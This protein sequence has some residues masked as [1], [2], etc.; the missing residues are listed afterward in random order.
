MVWP[1][2]SPR[3]PIPLP[4]DLAERVAIVAP[5]PVL[6]S[7]F[8]SARRQPVRPIAHRDD[9]FDA[10]FDADTLFFDAFFGADGR[11]VLMGPPFLNLLPALQTMT[12]TAGPSRAPCQF[13]IRELDR[14]AQIHVRAPDGTTSLTLTATFGTVEIAISASEIDLFAGRR[15]LFTLS[16]NNHLRW[17]KDWIRFARDIHGAD[18]VLFYDNN[19]THYTKADLADA[20]GSLDGL[21][22]VRVIDWP[23]RY[24]PQGLDA[25]RFWDSDY[26]QHGAW[27]HARRR[28]LAAARS[29]QNADVDELVVPLTGSSV[30]EAAERDR[31]GITRYCGRWVT[32]ISDRPATERDE[33]R[34]TDYGVVTRERMVRRYGLFQVDA[35]RSPQKWTVVPSRCPDGAQWRAHSIAGWLPARRTTGAFSYRHF[36][37]INDSWK[38]DRVGTHTFDATLH[39]ED[40]ALKVLFERVRWDR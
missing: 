38:Y 37:E 27:E 25:W 8:S 18:A 17:V 6:L 26:C 32:G 4:L 11:I 7:S 35:E 34:H 12:L 28:F 3:C 30:F 5:K 9:G 33:R 16:R 40:T 29:A 22:V 23:F 15:V 20:I 14:H 2:M 24:G 1:D 36:R 21:A 31:F 13:E 39:E 10:K 19:S